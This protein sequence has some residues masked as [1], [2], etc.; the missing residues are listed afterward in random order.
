MRQLYTCVLVGLDKEGE[1]DEITVEPET[2]VARDEQDAVV[3]FTAKNS[4]MITWEVKV[5]CRPF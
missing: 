5:L 4:H 2:I 1:I 3:K